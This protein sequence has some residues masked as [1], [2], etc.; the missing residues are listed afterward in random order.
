M[1]GSIIGTPRQAGV[2]VRR[3]R[4]KLNLTRAQLAMKSS[5]S[6]RLIASLELGDATG[7]RLDKLV[8]ILNALNLSLS[9]QPKDAISTDCP[10]PQTT[11][12]SHQP[13]AADGCPPL[14]FSYEDLYRSLAARQGIAVRESPAG[15]DGVGN[16]TGVKE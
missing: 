16:D 5:V 3:Q 1:D 7:I 2:Y 10:I 9:I 14:S 11:S 6:E 4:E 15:K 13:S 12:D 8:S